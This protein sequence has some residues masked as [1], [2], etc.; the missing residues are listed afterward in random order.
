MYTVIRQMQ[1]PDNTEIV[2]I[3][4]GGFDYVNPDMLSPKYDQEGETF[5]DP[6]DAV[7]AAI[8]IYNHW[9]ADAPGKDIYIGYGNTL[10]YTMPFE[11]SSIPD[12]TAW[13]EKE[14]ESL[15]KCDWCGDIIERDIWRADIPEDFRFCSERCA[16]NAYNDMFEE[17]IE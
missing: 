16:E 17:E 13:S 8:S 11:A 14:Y 15:D 7:D 3:L 6:R 9:R 5:A 1:F 10:G 12:I 2:E 4:E